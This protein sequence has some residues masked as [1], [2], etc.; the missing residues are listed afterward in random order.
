MLTAALGT[1]T[2]SASA[3]E[4]PVV[5]SLVA[6]PAMLSFHGG[7]VTVAAELEHA[8]SCRLKL[9]SQQA[10]TVVYANNWRACT[11]ALVAHVTVGANPTPVQRVVALD[12]LARDGSKPT[13]R[14]FDVRMAAKPAKPTPIVTP[15]PFPAPLVRLTADPTVL[16]GTGGTLTL[17]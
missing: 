2:A 1:A 14:A 16:P 11:T 15:S 13:A 3:I 6:L 5:V 8:T 12:L 4:M 10:F 7:T 17:N 9:L